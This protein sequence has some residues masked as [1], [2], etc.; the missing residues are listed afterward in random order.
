MQR[1]NLKPCSL[2][3]LIT[4]E[5]FTRADIVTLQDPMDLDKFN[6]TTFHHLN[7]SL[8]VDEEGTGE[9]GE[10]RGALF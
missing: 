8:T 2:R 6:M 4:D 3:D 10:V 7:H 5:T 9:G 1:L